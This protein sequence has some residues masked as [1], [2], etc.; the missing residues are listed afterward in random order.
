[1]KR[2]NFNYNWNN[3]LDAKIFTTIR[4][5]NPVKY[6]E[7]EEYEVFLKEKPRPYLA[8]CLEVKK[9][10]FSSL[11]NNWVGLD[12]GYTGKETQEILR[13]MYKGRKLCNSTPFAWVLLRYIDKQY[14][15][16]EQAEMS[17]GERYDKAC[18]QFYAGGAMGD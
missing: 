5:W 16:G 10:P 9:M 4:L 2:I 15:Q 18:R 12:T 7:G 3:K 8:Q 14:G 1:M 6:K 17:Y 11:D 13:T